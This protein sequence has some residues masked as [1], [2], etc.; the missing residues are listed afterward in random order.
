M[1][2]PMNV[3]QVLVLVPWFRR[4]MR[5]W[6]LRLGTRIAGDCQGP[7]NSRPQSHQLLDLSTWPCGGVNRTCSPGILCRSPAS[8][9]YLGGD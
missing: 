5:G 2:V 8:R 9:S 4:E 6:P 3:K 7:L 1:S